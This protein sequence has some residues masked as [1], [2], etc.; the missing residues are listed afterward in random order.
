[1]H[2]T[3][4]KLKDGSIVEG[5]IEKWKPVEGYLTLAGLDKQF[6]FEDM[7]SAVT[8][9]ERTGVVRDEN[10]KI[11]GVKIE[12]IDEIQRAKDYIRAFIDMED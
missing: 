9:D 5:Y 1:M 11:V 7:E 6:K 8:Y 10:D 4:L 3:K 12:D 2:I